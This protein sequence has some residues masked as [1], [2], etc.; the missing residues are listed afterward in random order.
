LVEKYEG[1]N[2]PGL[3]YQVTIA[4]KTEEEN[5][6]STPENKLGEK[7][8]KF[9]IEY[10]KMLEKCYEITIKEP[11]LIFLDKDIIEKQNKVI[12]FLIKKMGSNLI[13]GK[14]IMNVSLPVN[15]F[16]KRTLLQVY[17]YEFSF[18]S[19]YLSRAYY[20]TEAIEK[21][22]WVTVFLFS[23]LHLSPLQTKPFNPII[24]ETFQCKIGTVNFYAEQ[25]VNKP[26]TT[27]FYAFDDEKLYKVYGDISTDASTG[28]N[29]IKATRH[30]KFIVELKDGNQYEIIFPRIHIKG[31][32][33]GKRLFNFSKEAAVINH[34]ANIACHLVFNPDAKGAIMS[35]FS[36]KQKSLPSSVK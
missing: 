22:K 31:I 10:D 2:Y 27:N 25:T 20:C 16:D 14:S 17:A 21:L 28:A 8:I 26:P 13:K 34:K 36:S 9:A 24:G 33:V 3:N 6:T 35:I 12:S 1:K 11:G 30:G 29:S 5:L 15:I 32:T 19:F 7:I 4:S 23:Q 18:A